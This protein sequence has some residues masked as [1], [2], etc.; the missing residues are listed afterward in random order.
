MSRYSS[1]TNY[2]E[3]HFEYKEL[4][5]IHGEPTYDT[6][7]RLHNQVKANAAS[8]PSSLGGGMFGHLGL[9]LSPRAYALISNAPFVRPNH[10][11]PLV[12]PPGQTQAQI[13]ALED[14]H[15]EALRVFNEVLGVEANL[16]QQIVSAIE[17]PYLKAIRNRHSNA[18][19]MT[20]NDI[21]TQHL[22]LTY[23]DI[24][25]QQLQDNYDKVATMT[26]DVSFPP[27][28]VYECIEDLMDM[29]EAANAPFTERQ[30]VNLGY[31]IFNRT[32]RFELDLRSWLQRPLIQQTWINFKQH[33]T[34]AHKQMKKI[35]ALRINN[36][37][38]FQQANVLQQMVLAAV[39]DAISTHSPPSVQQNTTP[40]ET[41][42]TDVSGVTE[43]SFHNA[44]AAMMA[45][46]QQMIQQM[47]D[48]MKM[49]QLQ[50]SQYQPGGTGNNSATS[51]TTRRYNNRS[52][53]SG[54]STNS[55]QKQWSYCW[56][57]GYCKHNGGA[58]TFKAQGHKDAATLTDNMGGNQ[59]GKARWERTKGNE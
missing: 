55:Q 25:P 45:T 26:Y 59:K 48:M 51:T 57:H 12:I 41:A 35:G 42:S 5:K 37:M 1:A 34:T 53:T 39:E 24:D 28:T 15:R 9:V 16:R 27:D 44:N 47:Q 4:D 29:S 30:C 54:N 50:L 14:Q 8:V 31:N 7:K 32:G 3:T 10:P 58:C 20:V 2:I 33:F 38:E 43:P 17:A 23:G 13:K 22:Y 6:I 56:T 49:M 52:Q 40:P 36:T 46:N 21:F 18:I 19:N 11:G